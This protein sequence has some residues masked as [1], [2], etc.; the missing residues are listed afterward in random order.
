VDWDVVAT[1]TMERTIPLV[2]NID[3]AFTIGQ[4]LEDAVAFALRFGGRKRA[5][6][7]PT[8]AWPPL[9]P[10]GLYATLSARALSS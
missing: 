5:S 7:I 8:N 4:F 9:L 2:M 6:T 1:Q 10:S 3:Q